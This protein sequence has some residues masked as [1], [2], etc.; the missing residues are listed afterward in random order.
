LAAY[1]VNSHLPEALQCIFR[2]LR[3]N[4]AGREREFPGSTIV[5]RRG[6]PTRR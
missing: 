4:L 5:L 1:Q 2:R 6:T 3:K